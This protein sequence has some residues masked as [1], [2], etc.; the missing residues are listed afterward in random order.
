MLAMVIHKQ[1]DQPLAGRLVHL[2]EAGEQ[3][4]VEVEHTRDLATLDQRHDQLGAR[5]RVAGDMARK[6]VDVGD[7][8]RRAP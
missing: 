1:R 7:Q 4:A 3:R 8:N 5:S 6:I 2:V